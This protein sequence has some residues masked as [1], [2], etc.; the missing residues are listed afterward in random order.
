ML[1]ICRLSVPIHTQLT[2]RPAR[3][4]V[5]NLLM[6]GRTPLRLTFM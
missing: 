2:P 4:V 6:R 3:D 5:R 1:I